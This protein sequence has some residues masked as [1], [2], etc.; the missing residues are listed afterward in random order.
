L[1]KVN[2]L[3]LLF[4][5]AATCSLVILAA[6]RQ[7]KVALVTSPTQEPLTSLAATETADQVRGEPVAEPTLEPAAATATI[8]MY[9]AQDL[10]PTP[11]PTAYP[12]GNIILTQQACLYEYFFLPSPAACPKAERRASAAAE[13]P[14]ERGTMIWLEVDDTIIMLFNDH[15]WQ[16]VEDTWEEGQLESDPSIQPPA[17]RYQP[18]RGF[19][20]VW[21]EYGDIRRQLGWA[22]SPE[23]GF[24]TII[25]DQRSSGG[26]PE[27]SFLRL[28]NGQVAALTKRDINGGDWVIASSP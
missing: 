11:I 15:S 16:S 23:L 14:F 8:D 26:I 19:G 28:F 22:L 25:Q 24:E 5:L 17:D 2:R 6:C 20:K 13:Q 12:V 7:D 1:G 3:R 4:F 18:I 27:V 21:R 10:E 9:P